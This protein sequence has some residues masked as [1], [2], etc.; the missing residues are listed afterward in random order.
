MM[1][2]TNETSAD[3]NRTSRTLSERLPLLEFAVKDHPGNGKIRRNLQHYETSSKKPGRQHP[4]TNETEESA[5]SGSRI[6]IRPFGSLGIRFLIMGDAT[7]DLQ[8]MSRRRLSRCR[9]SIIC[10][11]RTQTLGRVERL[12][13][14]TKLNIASSWQYKIR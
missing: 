14:P 3:D 12:E 9:W 2:S 5:F 1:K 4:R 8:L 13:R 11:A 6:K 10:I 7:S